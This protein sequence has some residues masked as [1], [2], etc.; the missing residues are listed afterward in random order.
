MPAKTIHAA[1]NTLDAQ[2]WKHLQKEGYLEVKQKERGFFDGPAPDAPTIARPPTPKE[3]LKRIP[4]T[5]S[6]KASQY[7]TS[8]LSLRIQ[9]EI[10]DSWTVGY[11]RVQTVKQVQIKKFFIK[12]LTWTDPYLINAL[13]KA[14]LGLKMRGAKEVM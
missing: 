12:E 13:A 4:E 10:N 3:L 1:K 7:Q 9:K 6:V 14:W 5:L 2:L 11:R 8:K